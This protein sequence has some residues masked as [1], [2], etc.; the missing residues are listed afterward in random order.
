MS[1]GKSS[2]PVLL[3]VVMNC[4]KSISSVFYTVSPSFKVDEHLIWIEISGRPLC[5]WGS[6]AFKKFLGLF[7]KFM[8]FEIEQTTAICIEDEKEVEKDKY[9]DDVNFVD[10]FDD[11]INDLNENKGHSDI[12]SEDN[13]DSNKEKKDYQKIKEPISAHHQS[14]NETISRPPGFEHYKKEESSTS[15]CSTSLLD[16]GRRILKALPDVRVTALD[17][18]HHNLLCHVKLNGLKVKIKEWLGTTKSNKRHHKHE[19]LATLKIIEI[20]IDSNTFSLEDRK[21]RIKLLHEIDKIDYLEALDLL[22][23]SRIKWGIKGNENTKFFHGL[24]NKKCRTKSIQEFPPI[25]CPSTL[26]PSD[27]ELLEKDV[28]L[29]EIKIAVWDRGS[30]K[31]PGPDGFTFGLIKHYWELIKYDIQIF[32]SKFLESKQM[33]VGS[34][35]SFIILILKRSWIKACLESSR[36]SILVN[37]CPTFEFS[38][39]RGSRQGDPLSPFLF[40][41]FMEG[42][43]VALMEATQ[44]GLIHVIKI[45]SSNITLSHIF[46]A[47]D[48]VI[49]IEWSSLDMDNTIRVLYVFYL[50]SGLNINIHKSN[51]YGVG[52]FDNEPQQDIAPR[53][54]VAFDRVEAADPNNCGTMAIR[55]LRCSVENRL[56]LLGLKITTWMD[57]FIPLSLLVISNFLEGSLLMMAESFCFEGWRVYFS[58]SE[59]ASP[60]PSSSGAA[61]HGGNHASIFEEGAVS[62]RHPAYEPDERVGGESIW[63][64]QRSPALV[65]VGSGT[66]WTVY[67][68]LSGITR[69][70]GGAVDSVI[71]SPHLSGATMLLT[72]QNFNTN[73]SDPAG[74]GDPIL[75]QHLFRFFGH[76]EVYIPI[77]PGSGLSGMPRRVTDYPDGY[78][79]WNA[80]SSSGSYISVVGICRFFLVITITSSSGNNERC[81]LSPWAVEQNQTIP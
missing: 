67:S 29:D 47:D 55:I 59:G 61:P 18:D 8:F 77:L 4:M 79:G 44:Y 25:S 71:S 26:S 12:Y 2:S 75:Y 21:S 68:P 38:V 35:S 28:S 70:S 20:K 57:F 78:A 52:V 63:D 39:K 76:P 43:H 66:G 3:F 53:L 17:R 72:D 41:L 24:V 33:P 11:I 7:E 50:A 19:A 15:R 30:D 45:G 60:S 14:S 16:I 58:S 9:S 36:T 40:I 74:G 62:P 1:P 56:K 13:N 31:A 69:H 54:A 10:E 34:N 48:V 32:V 46:Y 5:T 6:A 80:L 42:I 49:T 23:K 51:V 65:E 81:A 73:L 37:R 27:H 22:Q 64:I